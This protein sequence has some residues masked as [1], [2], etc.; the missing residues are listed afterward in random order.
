MDQCS[1]TTNFAPALQRPQIPRPLTRA[2][3]PLGASA[4]ATAPSQLMLRRRRYRLPDHVPSFR[5][6]K[7]RQGAKWTIKTDDHL[8]R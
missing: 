5:H 3:P 4:A 2:V 1:K 8:L 6:F 7:L